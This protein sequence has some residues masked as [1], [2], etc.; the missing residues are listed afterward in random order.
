M[1][2]NGNRGARK[3]ALAQGL[4]WFSL[5]L[6]VV[7]LAAPRAL[8]RAIG[9]KGT[10]RQVVVMRAVGVREL[11]A[12]AGIFGRPKP[13]GWM[14][15]RAAGDVMDVALLTAADARSGSRRALALGAVA[16]AAAVD[17][18][19]GTRLSQ[20]AKNGTQPTDDTISVR[21]AITVQR[22]AEEV[23]AF[24]RDF[25]NLPR[26]M[27]HLERVDVLDEARSHWVAK[28]PAGRS[29][30]WDAELVDDRP[31]EVISWR[32]L[33][34]ATVE[35]EGSVHFSAAPGERGTEV[36]VDLRYSPPAGTLGAAV[37]KL[38][39]EEP[40]TQ[41]SDDL[42]RF[43]QVLE[44]GEVVRSDASP[45]GHSLVSHLMQRAAQP[46]AKEGVR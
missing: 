33:P 26:F 41:L 27:E 5:G 25:A 11:G 37:A 20:V 16:G 39:G 38:L 7:Q 3:D 19:E 44:T 32:S 21:K 40:A 8:A 15:A 45:R 43:K 31:G 22:P 12:A 2:V 14:W 6:G 18:L 35:N 28:G 46:M 30:E 10:D 9:L 4:G 36:L 1:Q 23:Y 13:G 34:G 24:W 42:R 17:V 29:V